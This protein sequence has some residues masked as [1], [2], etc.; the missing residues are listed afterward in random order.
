MSYPVLS[1]V[2]DL[3]QKLRNHSVVVLEAP[4]GA[5]KSTILPLHPLDIQGSVEV[6]NFIGKGH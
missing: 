5:G 3:K 4:P 1:I 6:E 2:E